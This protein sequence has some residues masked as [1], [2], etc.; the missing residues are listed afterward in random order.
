MQRIKMCRTRLFACKGR[1]LDSFPAVGRR[2]ACGTNA[3]QKNVPRA[4]RLLLVLALLAST[5]SAAMV[6]ATTFNGTGAVDDG[7]NYNNGAP[8]NANPGQINS[9]GNSWLPPALTDFAVRQTGGY[10]YRNTVVN[11]RGGAFN[12]G[13]KTIWEIEDARTDYGSYTNL[14]T[15]DLVMYHQNG[16][17]HELN[18]LSG[19]VDV[20][21]FQANSTYDKS[22]VSI[23]NGLF[24]ADAGVAGRTANVTFNFLNGGFGEIVI[25]DAMGM[26]F[27]GARLDFETGTEA[28]FT[29][30]AVNGADSSSLINW[31]VVNDR[32]LIDGTANTDFSSYSITE[33]GTATTITVI[34]KPPSLGLIL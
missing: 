29:I 31:L 18:I 22:S 23:K 26:D 16:E 3:R 15:S 25:A 19:V 13:K 1:V 8:D 10:V 20:G 6:T 24:H 32:V 14:Y 11:F 21:T 9:T 4:S 30:G 17:G 33:N 12:S 28:T 5:A 27:G 7:A 2:D 34:P